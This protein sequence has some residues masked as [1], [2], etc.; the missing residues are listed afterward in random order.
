MKLELFSPEFFSALLAIIVIDLVLAGDNAIVIAMAARNLPAHLQKKA[1]IWGAVGAIAVRSAMT[2]VVVY[3]LK[4]PGLMLIGGL[5]LVWIAYRLLNPEQENDEHGNAST[6][7]WG[8]MKTIVIADAI[9]GLDNVLAVA[10]ASHGSYVLVVLGLL[11]SIPVVIW[12]STQILKIVERYPS[13]TY[14]GAAVLAWTAAKMMISEPISQEWLASQSPVL[15]Y[16]IQVVVVLGVLTSGF[17]RSRRALEDVIAPSVVIPESANIVSSQQSIHFGESNMNKILIPV[18]SSKNSEMA[19][20][21]AVKTYGQ[22]PNASFHLCNV[23][24][25]LYRHIGKFLSKQTINEWHAERAALASASASAYLEKQGLKFSFTYVCGDTGTAIRDEAVRL[26]CDRI[27]VGTSKKNSLSRLFE[28]ST[29]A[30]LLEISDIPVE[31]VTGNSLPV[32]ERWGI[33]ALGAGAATALMA[34]VID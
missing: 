15:E 27:V 7:F 8:A 6:T 11:I 22:D 33:P 20:K 4:I 17:I 9:M 16:L 21:H 29:T 5:L 25:T 13:V 10:G 19:V 34:V 23:Q 18:D 12:G 31:V 28:N 2:L 30:K 26:E 32:L 14:L 3:L 24:P 1:I